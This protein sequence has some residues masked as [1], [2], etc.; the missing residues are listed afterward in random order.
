MDT[1]ETWSL[2]E[3]PPSGNCAGDGDEPHRPPVCHCP[4]AADPP[5]D[6]DIAT[7]TIGCDSERHGVPLNCVTEGP[8]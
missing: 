1:L 4:H 3:G 2:R 8:E 6:R 5:L 7:Q